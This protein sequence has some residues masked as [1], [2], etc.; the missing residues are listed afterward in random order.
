MT[1]LKIILLSFTFIFSFSV[2]A[3][4]NLPINFENNQIANQDIIHFNGGSGFVD[5][6]PQIDDENPSDYVGVIIRRI[7]F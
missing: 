4:I 6:N 7:G 3:Q 2:Y 5:Y 1:M